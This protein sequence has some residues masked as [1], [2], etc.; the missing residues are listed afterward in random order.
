[1]KGR[2]RCEGGDEGGGEVGHI[3]VGIILSAF[4][5]H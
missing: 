2:W 4:V 3:S 5:C 1:M